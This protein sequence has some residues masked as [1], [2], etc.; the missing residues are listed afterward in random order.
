MRQDQRA[1]EPLRLNKPSANPVALKCPL[2][3][4][5]SS[6]ATWVE[7]LVHCWAWTAAGGRGACAPMFSSPLLASAAA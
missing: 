5:Q 2:P 4:P 1:A 6:A 7:L 3:A